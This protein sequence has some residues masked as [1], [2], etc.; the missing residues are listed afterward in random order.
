MARIETVHAREVLDSRGRPTVEVE[1]HCQATHGAAWGRA[2]APSGASTGRHEAVERRDGDRDW[3]DGD[4]V[5]VAVQAVHEVIGPALAGLNVTDQFTIDRLLC[6]L[7]G[8]PNKQRL[9]A[10]AIL[11]V[12]LACAHAAA[13]AQ[14]CP[15]FRHIAQLWQAACQRATPPDTDGQAP[16]SW[17]EPV[18]PVPMINMISG[19]LHAGQQMEIQDIMIV[20]W[21][22]R[23]VRECLSW[24][25]RI[26]RRL[27]ELLRERGLTWALVADE[28]G[29]GPNV[30]T[31][32]EALGLVTEAIER[33]GL[34]P[35]AQ[36]A[37]ALDV[38]ASHFYRD[39]G[40]VIAELGG[41]PA[42][43]DEFLSVLRAWTSHFPIMSLEDVCAE[44]DWDGWRKASLCFG[45]TLQLVGDDLF[46]TNLARLRQAIEAGIANT[47]LIKPNQVGTLSET[48]EVMAVARQAGYHCVVSARSGETEDITI[49]H[50]AVGTGAGQIK[51]GSVTRSERLAK[52]NELLRIADGWGDEL[53]LK[54]HFAGV[55]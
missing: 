8:T 42:T 48:L 46:V 5:T 13:Q 50:L 32:D 35:G 41:G 37:L 7:D 17:G 12:S 54:G 43:A 49:A 23:S 52:Y 40:Y 11:P 45:R 26:Y 28:G 14:R 29:F 55:G 22:A 20:P 3:F 36:V 25:V 16:P 6:E 21:A 31:V 33:A 18:L 47:V 27:R 34:E 53:P 10:N 24:A 51:I 1:V 15:L 9:G 19:G 44:D 39:G 2:I 38:A 4:G 30:D